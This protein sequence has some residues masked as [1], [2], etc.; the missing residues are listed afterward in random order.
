MICTFLS[1]H[2]VPF[3]ELYERGRGHTEMAAAEATKRGNCDRNF[4]VVE[5]KMRVR[6]ECRV[7][8]R[9]CSQ[10]MRQV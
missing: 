3:P 9:L 4:M 2:K 8:E 7:K 5:V 10:E 6:I 1:T